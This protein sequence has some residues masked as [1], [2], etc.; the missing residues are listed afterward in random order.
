M[1]S[2]QR[3]EARLSGGIIYS[4]FVLPLLSSCGGSGGGSGIPPPPPPPPVVSYQQPD[5]A[6]C[7]TSLQLGAGLL[8]AIQ[9]SAAD[10]ASRDQY[11]NGS[12]ADS[13]LGFGYHVIAF[14]PTG[15]QIEGVYVHF[16]G[17]YGRPYNQASAN[18]PSQTFLEEALEAN[19]ITIQV[20]YNNRFSVNLDE[21]GGDISR[22]NV[23][24][25]S[26]D[27]REEKLT[28]IDVSTV[29]DTPLADGAEFRLLALVD[30]LAA[31]GFQFPQSFINN[32]AVNWSVL[33]VGGHSQGATHALY[34]GKYFAAQSVCM[35]AGGFDVPDT[36][37]ALPAEN[38]ADWLLDSNV[39]LDIDKVRAVVSVDDNSY[40]AFISAYQHLGMTQNVHYEEF[41]GAPYA[42]V[43]GNV[44]DGHKAVLSDPRY[45]NLRVAACFG[46]R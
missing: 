24:N 43:G 3:Q 18:Y 12:L 44:I 1:H 5:A 26:G 21:C 46:A 29:S 9:P 42:D 10:T 33:R 20:A 11:G 14:P 27:V 23:D 25:C 41:S 45:K 16:T 35:F 8:C 37:P 34:L 36:I 7:S 6:V 19:Y 2:H 31:R 13:V 17:S 38:L 4:L 30:Y 32:G 15:T 39:V 22:L 40:A 28:G